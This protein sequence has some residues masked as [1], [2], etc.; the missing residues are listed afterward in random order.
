MFVLAILIFITNCTWWFNRNKQRISL[1]KR[2]WLYFF[3]IY[4]FGSFFTLLLYIWLL[5]VGIFRT[6][7]IVFEFAENRII[8]WNVC[9]FG[10]FTLDGST[11]TLLLQ[12]VIEA[13]PFFSQIV[14][15]EFEHPITIAAFLIRKTQCNNVFFSMYGG[16]HD[17]KALLYGVGSL[18][19]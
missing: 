10:L 3:D 19:V 11:H 1:M 17:I 7:A 6:K 15:T 2:R 5:L 4:S 12:L 13:H 14:R 8:L 16:I 9:G 18:L